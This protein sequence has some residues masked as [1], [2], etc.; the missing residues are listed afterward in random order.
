[1]YSIQVMILLLMIV[2]ARLEVTPAPPTPPQTPETAPVVVDEIHI[3]RKT[4]FKVFYAE[5]NEITSIRQQLESQ[6]KYL[7]E[8]WDMDLDCWSSYWYYKEGGMYEGHT[9]CQ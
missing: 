2:P 6:S 1:M 3:P 9:S 4:Q 7:K 8:A 5:V